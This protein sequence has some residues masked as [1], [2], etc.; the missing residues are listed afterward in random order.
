MTA[1]TVYILL[2]HYTSTSKVQVGLCQVSLWVGVVHVA[3][4]LASEG[5]AVW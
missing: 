4:K 3:K 1:L 5:S 2:L